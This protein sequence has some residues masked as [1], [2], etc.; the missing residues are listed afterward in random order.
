MILRPDGI[1]RFEFI[2][3][4]RLRAHQLNQGCVPRVEGVHL[5]AV[6]AQM[7]VALG[8]IEQLAAPSRVD[9]GSESDS[10]RGVENLQ[11]GSTPQRRSSSISE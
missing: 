4:A 3:L 2:A 9:T 6:T 10:E 8:Y 5:R 11:G 7:E 1:G